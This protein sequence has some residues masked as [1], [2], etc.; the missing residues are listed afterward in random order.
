[1]SRIHWIPKA[2]LWL[3]SSTQIIQACTPEMLTIIYACFVLSWQCKFQAELGREPCGGQLNPHS[4]DWVSLAHLFLTMTAQFWCLHRTIWNNGA[5]LPYRSGGTVKTL[6]RAYKTT[7]VVCVLPFM[8]KVMYAT[9]CSLQLR[10]P[11]KSWK[12]NCL[13]QKVN[14]IE[15]CV[16]FRVFKEIVIVNNVNIK[17][18]NDNPQ[19]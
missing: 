9:N 4:T 7:D 12:T 17:R 5:S 16:L 1:M 13:K 6:N 18:Y 14:F 19:V 11:L 10:K 8:V 3:H 2:C 15:H